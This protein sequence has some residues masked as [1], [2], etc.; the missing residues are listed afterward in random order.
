VGLVGA[1][2]HAF[3][4]FLVDLASGRRASDHVDTLLVLIVEA[5]ML[6]TLITEKRRPRC[7]GVALGVACGLAY[8]TKSLPGL[9]L[10][11]I[12]AVIRSQY[13]PRAALL[14]DVAI[15]GSVALVI[16]LPWTVYSATAFP[17]EWQH[18]SL[19]AWRHVTEVLENQ[20]GPPWQYVADMPRFFGELVY[21]PLAIA[22][23]S[24][25]K[26]TAAPARRAMLLWIAVPYLLFSMMATK[27]PA[28]VMLTAP[29]LFLVQAEFWLWLQSWRAAE[30]GFWRKAVLTAAVIV[31]AL[32][33]ARHLL[34]PTGPL[35]KR[36][37]DPQWTRDLR[38]LNQ[39]IGDGKAVV[40]NV[41]APIEAMFYTPYVVYKHMPTSEQVETL[42]AR[43]YRIYVYE[44]STYGRAPSVRRLHSNAD[45]PR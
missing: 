8:L 26:G 15:A 43:G 6:A 22:I 24:V 19:Y 20:G 39:I 33:P 18:E 28:Y 9:L 1:A 42:Q 40:F 14:R 41:P 5:G 12:W 25:F 36:E 21:V 13:L 38:D 44:R 37:R 23:A 35:E 2:F 11:P 34:S 16:A 45:T 31:L 10:L 30:R 27:M 7:A 29:A 3:N 17:Q 32:F 4:G